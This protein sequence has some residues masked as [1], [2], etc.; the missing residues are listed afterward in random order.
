LEVV[1]LLLDKGADVNAKADSGWTA[2]MGAAWKGHL[3]VVKL[4]LEKGA[5]VDEGK[6]DLTAI[7]AAAG[8]GHLEVVKLLLEKGADVN[9]RDKDGSTALMSAAGYGH[10]ALLE[11]LLE[12]GVDV[13][14]RDKDGSTALMEAAAKYYRQEQARAGVR[15]FIRDTVESI[16]AIVRVLRYG[17]IGPLRLPR[18]S[19]TDPEVVKF[20][21]QKGA[22]VNARAADGSTALK[23]ARKAGTPE[24][25]EVLK[26]YGAKE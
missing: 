14:A 7:G 3:G 16:R 23:R 6:D 25:V 13:N 17:P 12:K 18:K 8:G 9:A 26:A 10:L 24:I 22:D 1:R 19:N 2:L 11:V 20:L 4:L 15:Q 5:K 21:L